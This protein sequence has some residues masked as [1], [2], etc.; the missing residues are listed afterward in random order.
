METRWFRKSEQS[1]L[2][3]AIDSIWAKGHVFTRNDT[4]L[5]H[6][7]FE[8]PFRNLVVKGDDFSFLGL[9]D[10]GR[11]V[12]ILGVIPYEVNV[13]GKKAL[14]AALTN[15]KVDSKY[16][17]AGLKLLNS[18]KR[19]NLSIILSLG[20][21]STVAKLYHALNWYV[22]DDV[23]RW[24]GFVN[25]NKVAAAIFKN[26]DDTLIS[27]CRELRPIIC[28]HDLKHVS[29]LDEQ[30][31]NQFYWNVFARRTIGFA[32]S[33][34]FLNWRYLKHPVFEYQ[35]LAVID[36]QGCYTG[37]LVYR[38]EEI[39]NGSYKIGR[40]VEFMALDHQS[41]IALANE[42]LLRNEDVL[43]WDFYNL[44]GISAWA[45]E[46]IGFQR[47]PD[48]LRDEIV[49]PTR[50]QPLDLSCVNMMASMYV[51]DDVKE[52]Y[53]LMSDLQWYVTKGDSDQDRP[54]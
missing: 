38:V 21:N 29:Y 10:E 26:T 20:I 34:A 37:L 13:K 9:W 6:M 44:S 22:L 28:K 5:N 14:G 33:Y 23:P 16:A 54:N 31:W 24:I 19:Y 42:I 47:K 25:R 45:L 53:N 39:M 12:G 27:S 36:Q 3:E 2:K 48:W 4:L 8:N 18:V 17:G 35:I 41:S 15:W 49:V 32:R 43:F 40:I 46:N 51:S 30:K 7:F 50:F 52:Q 11:I 1:L